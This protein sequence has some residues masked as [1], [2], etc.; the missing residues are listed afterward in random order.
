MIARGGGAVPTRK[1]ITY[2]SAS[3]KVS[4]HHHKA[5]VVHLSAGA[6]RLVRQ[7]RSTRLWANI[8]LSSGGHRRYAIRITLHR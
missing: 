7:H 5:I 4:A 6:K 1:L 8:K 3:F 2:G